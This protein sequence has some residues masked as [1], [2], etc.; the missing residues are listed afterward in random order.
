MGTRCHWQ[1]EDVQAGQRN[2]RFV[3]TANSNRMPRL[4]CST[5]WKRWDFPLAPTTKSCASAAQSP[6][7]KTARK[8]KLSLERSDQRSPSGSK[9]LAAVAAVYGSKLTCGH[10]LVTVAVGVPF[11]DARQHV[12]PS[13][14]SRS[15]QGLLPGFPSTP[16]NSDARIRVLQ[17]HHRLPKQRALVPTVPCRNLWHS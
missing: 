11:S 10:R 1:L 17:T 7:S 2:P 6:T 9:L 5:R 15:H 4:C 13:G 16:Q 12:K 8:S 14:T 3:I